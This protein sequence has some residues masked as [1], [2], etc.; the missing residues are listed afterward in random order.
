M[1]V[2]GSHFPVGRIEE[3][4]LGRHRAGANRMTALWTNRKGVEHDIAK[5]VYAR[6][7]FVFARAVLEVFDAALNLS[8][9][10][11]MG[12]TSIHLLKAG[13]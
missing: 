7:Q 1:F 12:R 11:R 5:A 10:Q 13:L 2:R 6:V 9:C 4:L 3:K 8:R